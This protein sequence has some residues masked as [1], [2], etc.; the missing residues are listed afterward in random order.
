MPFLDH[1][2]SDRRANNAGVHVGQYHV[3]N[4]AFTPG[5]S[6]GSK[7][8]PKLKMAKKATGLTDRGCLEEGLQVLHDR[9]EV[10]VVSQAQWCLRQSGSLVSD[11]TV[12]AAT[13]MLIRFGGL[14]P[15][16]VGDDFFIRMDD[17][18]KAGE[19]TGDIL[20]GACH[21]TP[22]LYV[23]KS[24]PEQLWYTLLHDEF[25]G[26]G[27]AN[28]T[29]AAGRADWSLNEC[30]LVSPEEVQQLRNYET[31]FHQKLWVSIDTSPA[32]MMCANLYAQKKFRV[33]LF[34]N[35][36]KEP[37]ASA[38]AIIFPHELQDFGA[39]FSFVI[40]RLGDLVY[41]GPMVN[42]LIFQSGHSV[43]SAW[44]VAPLDAFH[45]PVRLQHGRDLSGVYSNWKTC[46]S[47]AWLPRDRTYPQRAQ[48]II[49]SL[50][51][52]LSKLSKAFSTH[53]YQQFEE[54]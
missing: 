19:Y 10:G 35:L 2:A 24:A 29:L 49:T 46:G 11:P 32:N 44:N 25:G 30:L 22:T 12:L 28:V 38:D 7:W 17:G 9:G 15:D 5:S 33:P 18:R 51:F 3:D 20:Q 37:S 54:R 43:G 31:A 16:Y 23:E 36:I 6:T 34:R 27:F 47:R 41:G 39:D 26:L 52:E 8:N 53:A 13:N 42:H 48:G 45:L 1:A 4:R 21:L 40:Q 50:E 14:Q